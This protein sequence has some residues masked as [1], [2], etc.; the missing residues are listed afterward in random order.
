MRRIFAAIFLKPKN[1]QTMPLYDYECPAC[2]TVKEVSHSVAEI[3]KIRVECDA[4]GEPMK[5]LLSVPT[6]IGFDNVGRSIGRKEKDSAGE[7]KPA[8]G[9]DAKKEAPKKDVA[10]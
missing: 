7:A 5:K 9:A 10:A 3:G 8:S 2:G 4:C 1:H 6:L